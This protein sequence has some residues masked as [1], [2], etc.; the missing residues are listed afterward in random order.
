TAGVAVVDRGVGLDRTGDRE[1][2]RRS[3]RAVRRADDAGRHRLGKA[4][5]ASDG[6][7]ALAGLDVSRAAEGEGMELRGRQVDVDHGRVGR[8]VAADERGLRGGA[9]LELDLDRLG[10]L[11][12]VRSGQDVAFRVDL[13]AGSFRLLLLRPTGRPEREAAG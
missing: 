3:D 2:V 5:R 10:T 9:V 12:H 7:D 11:D 6:D 1:L 4:E 8:L 13:E